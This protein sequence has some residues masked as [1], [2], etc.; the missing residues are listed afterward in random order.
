M[1]GGSASIYNVSFL[2]FW[3]RC[4]QNTAEDVQNRVVR[5]E[6]PIHD[7]RMI[8]VDCIKSIYLKGE[9]RTRISFRYSISLSLFTRISPSFA[10]E[11]SSL[12]PIPWPRNFPA[13]F[14]L[15]LPSVSCCRKLFY[16]T[17]AIGTQR[18]LKWVQW[19]GWVTFGVPCMSLFL[20]NSFYETV[21][22]TR[23]KFGVTSQIFIKKATTGFGVQTGRTLLKRFRAV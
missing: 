9:P 11:L 12:Q 1:I 6:I 14:L 19:F 8:R 22:R 20:R 3:I 16:E 2:R 15:S 13:T 23:K 4:M 7:S 17:T 5:V 18:E 10:R 21:Y